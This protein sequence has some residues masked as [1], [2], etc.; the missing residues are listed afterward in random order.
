[1][2][3][4]CKIYTPDNWVGF[5]LDAV[6]YT[7]DLYGKRVLENSCGTGNILWALGYITYI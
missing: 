7:M 3:E 1:M 5:L 2:S 4:N 6:G